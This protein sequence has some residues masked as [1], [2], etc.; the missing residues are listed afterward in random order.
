MSEFAKWRNRTGGK[1]LSNTALFKASR[2]AYEAW[3]QAQ[4]MDPNWGKSGFKAQTMEWEWVAKAVL[5]AYHEAG[6]IVLHQAL[7]KAMRNL[8]DEIDKELE[9]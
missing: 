3:C 7:S 4:N 9:K 6:Y 1:K 2:S 5:S 8:A